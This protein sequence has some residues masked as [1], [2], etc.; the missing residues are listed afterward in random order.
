MEKV[1]EPS[2][3]LHRY[4][5]LLAKLSA[6]T[7]PLS[8]TVAVDSADAQNGKPIKECGLVISDGDT[9]NGDLVATVRVRDLQLNEDDVWSL[10]PF[11]D[12]RGPGIVDLLGDTVL[13]SHLEDFESFSTHVAPLTWERACLNA[14][15]RH[16]GLA[17]EPGD[18]N[19]LAALRIQFHASAVAKAVN[20]RLKRAAEEG[21]TE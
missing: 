13:L 6:R 1:T 3:I 15:H 18:G 7:Y 2:E 12:E 16:Y 11:F 21:A 4:A 9:W 5:V 8:V 17:L 20:A 14:T 10:T 19:E